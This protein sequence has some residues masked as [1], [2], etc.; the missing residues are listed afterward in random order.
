VSSLESL[1]EAM[2]AAKA[3]AFVD[4]STLPHLSRIDP[5][6]LE[7]PIVALCSDPRRV[8]IGWLVAHPWLCHVVSAGLL[9]LPISGEHLTSVL[10]ALASGVK[11]RLLDWVPESVLGR[12]IRLTHASRRGPRLERM[13]EF[14][15]EHGVE[16]PTISALR[17]LGEE[18][19]MS[20]FY[21]SP[22][23]AGALAASVSRTQDVALPDDS[24]CDLAYGCRDDL[25]I[26]RVRDPFGSQQRSQLVEAVGRSAFARA[27]CAAISVVNGRSTEVLTTIARGV[28]AGTDAYAFHLFFRNTGKRRFWTSEKQTSRKPAT[29]NRSIVLV[30]KSK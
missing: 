17:D 24:A 8:A 11:P 14:L 3:V 26:L 22:V 4:R 19:L 16:A 23:A 29:T 15:R 1:L 5:M 27:T 7:A 2:R 12:R 18:L 10:N 9:E 13:A 21:E 30:N 20:A 25:A 6:R 28:P